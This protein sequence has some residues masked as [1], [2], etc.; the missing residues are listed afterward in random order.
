VNKLEKSLVAIPSVRNPEVIVDYAK[1]AQEHNFPSDKLFFLIITEDFADKESYK[2][3]LREFNLDGEVYGEKERIEYFREN[4]IIEYADLVPKRSHAE[5]TFGLIY[6][7]LNKEFKYGFFIDDDTKPENQFDYFG[8]HIK[9]LEFEGEIEEVSSSNNWVNVLY[10]SF[11]RHHL[12][13]RG[14]PYSKM[15][16]SIS[17][18]TTKIKAGHIFISH[19]LWTNIPDLDAVR[20]LMDGDLNGQA[21]TRLTI[22]DF[23]HN[24]VT[25]HKNFQTVCSMNLAFRR[26]IVPVFYQ[27][28]MD[29]NPFH[30]GRFDDIWSGL[31]AKVFLDQIDGYIINGFPLC[32]HNKA[33]RSTFKDLVAEA[34]GYESNECLSYILSEMT[35]DSNNAI[36]ITKTIANTLMEKGRT[37]FLRYCGK[38]LNKYVELM[39]AIWNE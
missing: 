23:K 21:K 20:I 19:G 18:N 29:D 14:Y 26:E 33:P 30:I 10:Q 28:P 5:T 3:K 6:M 31:V 25:A 1:N 2:Q 17:L 22:N 38:Y 15:H 35:C 16:E 8:D 11:G 36:E 32:I 7:T 9:N 34:P 12:Y 27:F 37:E 4:N 13:P 24:F 39:E